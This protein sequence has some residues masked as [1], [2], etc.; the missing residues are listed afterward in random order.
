MPY[1]K[2]DADGAAP[3]PDGA[4][5]GG[6]RLVAQRTWSLGLFIGGYSVGS[7]FFDSGDQKPRGDEDCRSKLIGR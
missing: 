3:N 5:R 2:R 7:M 6:L 1:R 4:K